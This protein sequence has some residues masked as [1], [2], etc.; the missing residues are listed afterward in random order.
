MWVAKRKESVTSSSSS[1]TGSDFNLL[2]SDEADS[3]DSGS[4]PTRGK[5]NSRK[6]LPSKKQREGLQ[7]DVVV[8]DCIV[9][10]KTV[11][12]LASSIIDGR[13]DEQKQR[14]MSCGV[15]HVVYLVEGISL[16]TQGVGRSRGRGAGGRGQQGAGGVAGGRGGGLNSAAVL[17]ALASTQVSSSASCSNFSSS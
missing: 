4:T 10:R 14:L 11:M 3:S 15:P 16:N 13:Y 9:E 17:S 1:T 6:K 8:L 5:E 2:D 7:R 12:D